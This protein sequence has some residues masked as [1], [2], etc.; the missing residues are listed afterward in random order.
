MS[1][2]RFFVAAP[3]SI[4]ATIALEPDDMHHASHVLRLRADAPIVVVAG[5]VA[6]D[7]VIATA[8]CATAHI[9]RPSPEGGGDIGLDVTILQAL[10]KGTKFDDVVEKC[11][12][13]GARRIVPVRCERSESEASEHKVER[14][15]RI[16]R[17]AA[18]QSRRNILPTVEEPLAFADALVAVKAT[19]IVASERAPKGSLAETLR[20]HQ[21]TASFVIAIGP[22]GSFTDVEL[23]LAKKA[24]ASFVSLGPAILRTETAA[25]A[26]LAAIASDRVW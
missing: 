19:L 9:L 20:A 25:A 26:L 22:E 11:V 16:A 15:R 23:E 1:A 18:Q 13:L 14:W 4:G 17:S 5:G 12:E 10:I 3:V 2:P 21:D 8:D 7:A 24:G 6:W